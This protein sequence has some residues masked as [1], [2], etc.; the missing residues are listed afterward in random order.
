MTHTID[1]KVHDQPG[2]EVSFILH[3]EV[4]KMNV[5]TGTGCVD[6]TSDSL[7]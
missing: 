4:K 3:W 1:R 7:Q 5:S 6:I 2:K